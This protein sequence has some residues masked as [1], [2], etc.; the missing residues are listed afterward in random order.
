M[1][2]L[3]ANELYNRE[4]LHMAMYKDGKC[5]PSTEPSLQNVRIRKE[6]FFQQK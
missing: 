1:L 4:C 2:T 5:Q 6:T 3:L